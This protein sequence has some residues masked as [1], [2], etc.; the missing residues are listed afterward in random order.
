MC[1]VVEETQQRRT[2]ANTSG[3]NANAVVSTE[4]KADELRRGHW[5]ID[6]SEGVE[7]ICF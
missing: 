7:K 3:G 4:K 2:G 5:G 6:L 1:G